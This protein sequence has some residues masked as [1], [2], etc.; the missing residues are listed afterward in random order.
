VPVTQ[1]WTQ[2]SVD[3]AAMRA[4]VSRPAAEF[5]T[6]GGIVVIHGGWGLE[7]GLFPL[8]RRFAYSGYVAVLPDMYHR[9]PEDDG[10]PPL[11][12]I[13]KLTWGNAKKDLGVALAHLRA[14]GVRRTAIVGFC[15]GGALA[16]MASAELGFDAGVLYYPHETFGAFGAGTTVPFDLTPKITIPMLGHFG[17]DDKNPSPE[18]MARLDAALTAQDTPHQF[19]SYRGAGHGFAVDARPA[20]RQSYREVAANIANDRTIGWFDRHLRN[21][22]V[23][24]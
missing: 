15:M 22:Q 16:W 5:A 8:M 20:G 12:R 10:Q 1:D 21:A 3:G 19:Y 11:G 4:H 7:E 6:G 24:H 18:D 17:A 23:A 14:Q 9:T 13:A 2:L